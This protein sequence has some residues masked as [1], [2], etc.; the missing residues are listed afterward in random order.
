MIFHTSDLF[1]PS[2]EELA[3]IS[4]IPAMFI[5]KDYWLTGVLKN[6]SEYKQAELFVFKGGTSLSKAY[7][8]IERFSEDI[9]L[10]LLASDLSGNQV[11]MR[12]KNTAKALVSHLEEVHQEQLTSKSSRFRRTAHAF[13]TVFPPIV[14]AQVYSFLVLEI[15]AFGNPFPFQDVKMQSMIGQ[16]FQEYGE[17][18]LVEQYG[19]QPFSIQVLKPERTFAEKVLAVVRSSCHKDAIAQLQAKIRHIYDLH[20]MMQNSEIQ[21]FFESDAFFEILR[22]VQDDDARNHEFQGEWAKEPLA[23]ALVFQDTEN[24]WES[25]NE[26]YTG[27]FASLVYG[28]LPALESI[29]MT[30]QKLAERLSVFDTNSCR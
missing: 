27:P 16:Y 23:K 5:E 10:A 29:R 8:M 1:K 2:I 26:S 15:N 19:L 4:G 12:I 20:I 14:G 30:F 28:K 22:K 11:K 24:L 13:T 25:L 17:S 21:T 6:L 3:L 18:S 9:D 7:G